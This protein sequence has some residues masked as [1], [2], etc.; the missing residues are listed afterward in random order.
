MKNRKRGIIFFDLD[1]TILDVSER[2]YCLYRKILKDRQK[3]YLSKRDYIKLKR[4]KEGNDVILAKTGAEDFLENFNKRWQ[5]DVEKEEFL[6]FDR[7]LPGTR[8]ALEEIKKQ[9]KLVLV[10]LRD[11]PKN[12]RWELKEKKI[13]KV[14]DDVLIE[15]GRDVKDKYLIKRDLI[16]KYNGKNKL[17]IIGDTET[18]IIAGKK[19]GIETLAVASGMRDYN[20]LK[21]Q[22]PTYLIKNL[23]EINNVFKFKK[24]T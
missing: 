23:G 9:Y 4:Q 16:N 18:D 20:F 10:T 5:E 1:G 17:C 19:L 3:K 8:R 12:L 22:N 15:S 14:F 2:V 24:T 13:D 6:S 7:V 11:N 21:K